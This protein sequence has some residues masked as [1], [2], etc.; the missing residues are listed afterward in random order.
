MTSHRASSRVLVLVS[1]EDQCAVRDVDS[2]DR[3]Y[4]RQGRRLFAF[5]YRLAG[6]RDLAEDLFQETWLKLARGWA[7]LPADADVEAWLFT[8][9]RNV[10]I[11]RHRSRAAERRSLDR[12]SHEPHRAPH[13]PDQLVESSEEVEVLARAFGSLSEDDKVL[14]WLVA[15]E[16]LDQSRVAAIM[17]VG[18]PALR[19][20]LAR[21]RHKLAGALAAA[22]DP[23][24]ASSRSNPCP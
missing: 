16:D 1:Q 22:S 12:L 15:I 19:Q 8:V 24:S 6:G 23:P 17:Q 4:G 9:A 10:F 5:L 18:Y 7:D 3:L 14:L 20:R 11:S 21:A 13:R 2:L